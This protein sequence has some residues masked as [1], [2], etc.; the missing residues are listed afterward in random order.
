[1]NTAQAYSQYLIGNYAAPLCT[2]ER[3]QGAYVYTAEGRRLLDFGSGIA[4]SAIGHCHPKWSQALADTAAKLGHLSNLYA[5][6]G[7]AELA[8]RLADKA[9]GSGKL[10]F[11][12][13]G[14]E[15]NEALIKLAR[16]HGRQQSGGKEGVRYKV[17][18][19][20]SAFHGRTFGSMA[21]TPQE[22]I[23][24]GFRPMLEGF[25]FAKLND[26]ESFSQRIDDQT[27]AVML[28][29]IQGESG[30]TPCEDGFLQELRALCTERG[31]LLM[32]D[33][34]QCG[35]GRTGDFFAFE[36][37]GVKP[38]AIGMAKG[39][40]GGFPIGAIW[41]A[42]AYAPL[43]TPGS[44]GTTFG[45]GPLACAAALA[46]L[47][48]LEEENLQHAVKVN[49]ARWIKDLEALAAEF[50]AQVLRVKGRGY[51]LGLGLAEGVDV[52]ALMNACY[53]DGLLAV[54]AGGNTLRLLPPLNVTPEHLAE[55][56][57]ILRKALAA[58]TAK[59]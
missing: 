15:A 31:V 54:P 53:A 14:T 25:A 9:G 43:F 1:M 23:Q 42:D 4:V 40:G 34:V 44:H 21:A 16:L 55:A 59:A 2:I 20:Q 30:V 36:R 13:S 32:L 26:I 17:V 24:S 52:R 6:E 46:T 33:E 39:L 35:I 41:V 27:A 10:L 57:A 18:C 51:M 28:E 11:C 29:T 49:S 50:P 12:N 56:T 19:A 5:H 45:G 58:I 48:V 22:K 8:R 37:S 38:D 7:Q 47:D 3:A